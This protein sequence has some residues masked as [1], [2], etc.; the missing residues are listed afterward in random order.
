MQEVQRKL[1]EELTAGTRAC[2][3]EVMAFV[4]PLERA[5]AAEADRVRAALGA[6]AALVDRLAALQL[7]AANVE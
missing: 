7:K 1:A 2:G 3:E 4:R 6:R 5:T